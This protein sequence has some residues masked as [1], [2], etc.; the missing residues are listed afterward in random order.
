[1]SRKSLGILMI[2]PFFSPNI[3][4]VETHLDDLCEYLRKRGHRIFVITYQPLTTRR[5]A[6]SLEVKQGVVVSR[7]SWFGYGL[8]NKLEPYPL[9]EVMYLFPALYF[10]TLLFVLLKRRRIDTV[11]AHGLVASLVGKFVKPIFRKRTVASVHTIYY[12]YRR[13]LL[14]RIFAWVLGSYDKILFA[15]ERMRRE[16][17]HFGIEGS[18]TDVFTYWADHTRFK[19]LSKAETKKMLDWDGKFVVL[20]V[21]RLIKEKG[22]DVL[23]KTA[24]M[25]DKSIFYAF[26]TSASYEEFKR[27]VG[28]N[29]PSNVIYVG[30]VEYSK[31]HLYYSAADV[32]VLPSQYREGFSRAVIEAALCGTPVIASNIGCLP[33]VVNSDIGCLVDPPTAENFAKV[34]EYY[35]VHRDELERLSRTC[36]EFAQKH[37]TENNAKVVEESYYT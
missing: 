2:T 1:M 5:K 21:G 35:Y 22:A 36:A 11:V 17:L 18:R 12:L 28:G 14:G 24:R 16:F 27:I 20:F 30:P 23:V 25:I 9:F 32:F 7:I 37:F 34:I 6:R 4:G 33:E 3:G 15:S 31:L 29:V 19:S 10:R 26:I 8:F 13:P